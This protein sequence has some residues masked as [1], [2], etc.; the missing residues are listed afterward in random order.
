MKWKNVGKI[1]SVVPNRRDREVADLEVF[2]SLVK[3]SYD[4]SEGR[5]DG[6]KKRNEI[7]RKGT[8]RHDAFGGTEILKKKKGTPGFNKLR[9]KRQRKETAN[10]PGL[11]KQVTG[12]DLTRSFAERE[13]CDLNG[14]TCQGREERDGEALIRSWGGVQEV[15]KNSVDTQ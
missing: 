2:V 15:A 10:P 13:T 7:V 9:V 4:A 6:G 12:G 14:K 8:F 1:L 3:Y 5:S 11:A